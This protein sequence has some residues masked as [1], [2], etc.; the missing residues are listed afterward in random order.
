MTEAQLPQALS[1]LTGTG[2]LEESF[3]FRLLDPAREGFASGQVLELK[4]LGASPHF[5][6]IL[7]YVESDP[8]LRGLVRRVLIVDPNGNRNRFDF[9]KLRFNREVLPSLFAY[10]PPPGTRVISP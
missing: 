8:R 3:S 6:R 5:Q 1:F 4:P 7:F 2:R 9:S 10:V